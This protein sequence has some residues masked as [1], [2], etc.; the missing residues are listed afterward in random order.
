MNLDEIDVK[1]LNTL[2]E[3]G[4]TTNAQLAAEAGISPPGMLERVKRLERAGVMKKY[5]A[6][7]DHEKIGK[8]TM[9]MVQVSLAIHQLPSI[10]SFTEEIN[11]LHEVLECYHITGE[12]DFL[13][14]VVVENIQAYEKFILEKLTRIKGIEKIKTSFVLSTI[15]YNTHIPVQK[16]PKDQ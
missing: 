15:K 5:V 10:D 2:Q 16:T 7:I 4:R 14:K 12:E 3:N 9:A 11:K 13:L 1:I 6:L 8:G